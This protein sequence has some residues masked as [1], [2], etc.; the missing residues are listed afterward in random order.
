MATIF[1]VSGASV[2]GSK[3][4]SQEPWKE[5]DV[6]DN[7]IWDKVRNF[8]VLPKSKK[9]DVYNFVLTKG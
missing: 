6:T 4:P 7:N 2:L 5:E 1:G 9:H 3:Q 8:D